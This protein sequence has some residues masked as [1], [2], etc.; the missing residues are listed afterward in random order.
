MNDEVNRICKQLEEARKFR[1]LTMAELTQ[2]SGISSNT[3]H[4]TLGRPCV[5]RRSNPRL[6]TIVRVVEVL[7]LELHISVKL[8]N[9]G[10]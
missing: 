8:Q 7:G 4:E 10:N 1:G 2:K 9:I 5:T 3:V 6:E